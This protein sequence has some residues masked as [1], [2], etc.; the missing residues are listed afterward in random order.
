VLNHHQS[1]VRLAPPHE[2]NP[3]PFTASNIALA[4]P[5][6][7]L[8]R[9]IVLTV[10]VA[11]AASISCSEARAQPKAIQRTTPSVPRVA[12]D[13]FDPPFSAF[14]IEASQRFGVPAAWIRAVMRAE[15]FGAVRAIS[16]KGAMGLMQIMPAT[17]AGL[18]QR[19]RLGADPYDAHDNIIAGAAYLRELHDRYG[20]PGFLAAYNAG[21]ARW[22]DHLA[23]GR[24]LP[25]ETRAYLARLAPVVGGSA[26][27][28]AV[29]LA[30]IVR[31]WAEASVFVA[32]SIESLIGG[33]SAVKEQTQRPTNDRRLK[34]L[35]GLVPQSG[36]LFVALALKERMQ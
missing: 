21:P 13:T 27:D 30:S 15:S 26:P 28:D 9:A 20:A 3:S 32:R 4:E 22:E 36:G 14:V 7:P 34:D 29:P 10:G 5:R 18:R 8:R 35:T 2:P 23:T 11:I 19:Y 24:P 33:Q 1:T 17:W 16:P 6:L 25:M 12:R 31:S